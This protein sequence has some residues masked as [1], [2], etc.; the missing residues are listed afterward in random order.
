MT[1][2]KD[3]KEQTVR[4][5]I[6]QEEIDNAKGYC[7]IQ[8]FFEKAF[9]N[10]KVKVLRSSVQIFPQRG[11]KGLYGKLPYEAVSFTHRFDF[12]F[13]VDVIMFSVD[14]RK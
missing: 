8:R 3:L 5:S 13:G 4:V 1:T 7:P 6:S 2:N 11:N 9:P 10:F 12:K 14:L